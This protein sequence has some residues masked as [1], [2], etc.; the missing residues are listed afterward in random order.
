MSYIAYCNKFIFRF[1]FSVY[2]SLYVDKMD[3]CEE[4][5]YKKVCLSVRAIHIATLH[6]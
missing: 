1:Y 2:F 4:N 6:I 3:C 5:A